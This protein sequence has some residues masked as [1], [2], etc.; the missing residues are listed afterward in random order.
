MAANEEASMIHGAA[1]MPLAHRYTTNLEERF[2]VRDT[3]LADRG[4]LD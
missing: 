3:A 1:Q 4:S 2:I